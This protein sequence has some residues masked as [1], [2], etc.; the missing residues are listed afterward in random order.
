MILNKFMT[1]E[2]QLLKLIIGS[3][4]FLLVAG[5]TTWPTASPPPPK[6]ISRPRPKPVDVKAQRQYYD[7]GLQLYSK[8]NYGEAKEAFE[9]VVDL[10]PNTALGTKA[11][12]NL[13]KIQQILKTLE[14]IEA[15]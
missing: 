15:K 1:M 8:E 4:A 12:E 11:R 9:Q 13:K 2:K 5:C 14:E 6:P 7:Q 10:G 3:A